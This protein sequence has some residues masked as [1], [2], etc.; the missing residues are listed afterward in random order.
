[1]A[2]NDIA[3]L[4]RW[5]EVVWNEGREDLMEDLAAS[6]VIVHGVGGPGQIMRGIAAFKPF[7]RNIRGAFPDL[8]ITVEEAIGERDIVA[9]RWSAEM[10]HTGGDLGFAPTQQRLAITGM[11]F[12]RVRDGKIVE[13]WDNWDMMGLMNKIGQTPHADVVPLQE[14]G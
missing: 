6:D 7:Y 11:T 5:F 10:T 8:R 3:I 1:M 13:S 12:A 4:R 2:Q 9:L 14:N